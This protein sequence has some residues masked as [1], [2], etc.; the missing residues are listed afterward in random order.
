[1]PSQLILTIGVWLEKELEAQ[2]KAFY[3]CKTMIMIL[4]S[5]SKYGKSLFLRVLFL[6][7]AKD[8]LFKMMLIT[9]KILACSKLEHFPSKNQW[10]LIKSWKKYTILLKKIWIIE[11][12]E[13][14]WLSH[15]K[16]FSISTHQTDTVFIKYIIVLVLEMK[17]L[18]NLKMDRCKSQIIRCHIWKFFFHYWKIEIKLRKLKK[19]LFKIIWK[20]KNLITSNKNK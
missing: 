17:N 19:I 3:R 2:K 11:K 1:M 13:I 8:V 7:I 16:I 9:A 5:C 4:K 12:R 20:L 15:L 14:Q 6:W 10:I 18:M